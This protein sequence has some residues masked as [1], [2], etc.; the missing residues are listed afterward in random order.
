[1]ELDELHVRKSGTSAMGD[2]KAITGRDLRVCRVAIN[3]P[4][5]P[6]RQ[7][8]RIGDDFHGATCNTGAHPGALLYTV[9]IVDHQEVE[10]AGHLDHPDVRAFADLGHQRP[11]HLRAG[12]VAVRVHDAI[13]RVGRF[14]PQL[15]VAVGIE[16]EPGARCL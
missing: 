1:M 16:V 9:A 3:L 7:H 6:G 15:E 4:A 10:H 14:L 13:A 2:R 11:R 5:A 12:L 8:R